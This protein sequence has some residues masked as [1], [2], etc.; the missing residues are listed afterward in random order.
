MGN[1][2]TVSNLNSQ[3]R[4]PRCNSCGKEHLGRCVY[5]MDGSFGCVNRVHKMGYCPTPK[6]KGME[7]NQDSHGCLN[8]NAPKRNCFYAHGAKKGI[9][10]E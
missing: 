10:P 3:E 7:V 4:S 2:V 6:S 8:P 9:N 5:S 1:K